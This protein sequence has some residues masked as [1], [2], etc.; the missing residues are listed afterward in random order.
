MGKG[1]KI[2]L[3]CL[4]E[5]REAVKSIPSGGLPLPVRDQLTRLLLSFK[6]G[7]MRDK[8][9]EH[10]FRQSLQEFKLLLDAC[11]SSIRILLRG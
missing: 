7:G 2:W 5:A 4:G 10:L 8:F 3:D 6:T 11:R 1:D 9:N